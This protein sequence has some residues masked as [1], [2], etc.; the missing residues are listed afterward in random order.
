MTLSAL[1]KENR[2][3]LAK[4]TLDAV[5][6]HVEKQKQEETKNDTTNAGQQRPAREDQS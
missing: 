5:R 1:S 6:R 2:E 3:L 4:A